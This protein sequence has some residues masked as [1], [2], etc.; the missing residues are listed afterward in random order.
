[1]VRVVVLVVVTGGAVVEDSVVV[2]VGGTAEA[3]APMKPADTASAKVRA[4][5]FIIF[6][7][8]ISFGC[9]R[10]LR[11]KTTSFLTAR[12]HFQMPGPDRFT[13]DIPIP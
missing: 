6:M 10:L 2:V 7:V 9:L 1:V 8:A 5:F 3:Q 13:A 4:A 11:A 12:L